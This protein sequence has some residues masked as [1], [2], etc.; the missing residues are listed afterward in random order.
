LCE[1]GCI[2]FHDDLS[3]LFVES[4]FVVSV[5][6]FFLFHRSVGDVSDWET[7]NRAG[8]ARA[9]GPIDCALEVKNVVIAGCHRNSRVF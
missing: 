4:L 5:D 8:A 1:C 9:R 3:L 2:A 6:L 7:A